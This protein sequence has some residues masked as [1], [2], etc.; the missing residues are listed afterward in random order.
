M[1]FSEA[2]G[3]QLIQSSSC[4]SLFPMRISLISDTNISPRSLQGCLLFLN[5]SLCRKCA[6]SFIHFQHLS[7]LGNACIGWTGTLHSCFL[8]PPLFLFFFQWRYSPTGF[9][10]EYLK[11]GS[12]G[13]IDWTLAPNSP[14]RTDLTCQDKKFSDRI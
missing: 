7:L 9:F 10:T 3:W 14:K 1:T 12:W 13:M 2:Q 5:F 6:C 11:E 8:A 4:Q